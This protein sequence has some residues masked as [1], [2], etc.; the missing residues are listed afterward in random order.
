MKSFSILLFFWSIILC[1]GNYEESVGKEEIRS[2]GRNLM[3]KQRK[4]FFIENKGQWHEDVLFLCRLGGLD[5]WITKYGVNYTFYKI[6]RKQGTEGKEAHLPKG[7]FDYD[8]ESQTL[9][10]HRVLFELQGR[11]PN[12]RAEGR[13]KMEGYHNYFIGNDPTKH[14]ANVALYKEAWVKNVYDGIDMRYYFEEGYL[15]FD[16]VVQAGADASKIRFKL[17]GAEGSYLKGLGKLAFTTRFGEVV[18]ADLRTLQDKKEVYSRYE[19]EGDDWK[20]ILGKYNLSKPLIIDPLIYSTYIGGVNTYAGRAIKVDA[21]GNAY[22]CGTNI[23]GGYDVVPG[24]FDNTHNG[25]MDVFVTMVAN[26]G[27]ALNHS[28]YLG[29][30]G[31]DGVGDLFI[32]NS[33]GNIYVVGVT[34]STNFP[35]SAFPFQSSHGNNNGSNNDG[36]I[37]KFDP[38]LT[39][40]IYSSYIGGNGLD[41]VTSVYVN[42]SGEAYLAGYTSSTNFTVTNTPILQPNLAGGQDIFISKVNSSGTNILLS[43]Y[44]GGTAYDE[45]SVIKVDHSGNVYVG[46]KTQ[47]A[48]FPMVNPVQ[49][50]NNGSFDVVFC[51]INPTFSSLLISTYVGGTKE[52]VC[53]DMEVNSLNEI[54]LTGATSSTNFPT[55]NGCYD[56]SYNDVGYSDCFLTKFNS[57]GSMV[58][59]TYF[60]GLMSEE[61]LGIELDALNNIYITGL[62]SSN[63]FP[64]KYAF[65]PSKSNTFDAFILKFD[66]S[67]NT[68]LYS[69][70]LGGN[71]DEISWDIALDNMGIAYVTGQTASTDFVVTQNAYQQS[72]QGGYDV[73]VT[74]LCPEPPPMVTL[75]S[76]TTSI[77][78]TTCISVPISPVTFSSTGASTA[79][80]TGLPPGVTGFYNNG[81]FSISGTPSS[82]GIYIYTVTFSGS[83][84]SSTAITGTLNVTQ[85][86]QVGT[87]N[88]S[89]S[90]SQSVCTNHSILPITFTYS[91]HNSF[92][93]VSGLPPGVNFTNYVS[94]PQTQ[95]TGTPTQSGSYVYSITVPGSLC[96]TTLTGTISVGPPVTFTLLSPSSYTYQSPCI[97]S[98]IQPI[99]YSIN[100]VSSVVNSNIPPGVSVSQNGNTLTI[101]GTPSVSGY[102]SY[103]VFLS[104]ACGSSTVKGFLDIQPMP[105]LSVSGGSLFQNVCSGNQIQGITLNTPPLSSVNVGGLPS[106]VTFYNITNVGVISGTPTTSPGTYTYMITV[107]NTCGITS[108]TGTFVINSGNATAV[109]I[110]PPGTENQTVCVGEGITPISYSVGGVSSISVT[111]LPAGVGYTLSPG[112]CIIGG[113][114]LYPGYYPYQLTVFG[115]GSNMVVKSGTIEAL[116][117]ISM[118]VTGNSS[119]VNQTLCLGRTIE[120]IN[121]K[122][123]GSAV[124]T[125][126]VIGLPSGVEYDFDNDDQEVKIEG[127]P[128]SIGVYGYTV[129]TP[130]MCLQNSR[131]NI[132][133]MACTNLD[134]PNGVTGSGIWHI[135]NI[136]QFP[137]NEVF[138]FSR[139]GNKIAYIKGYNNKDRAWGSVQFPLNV[140]EGTYYYIIVLKD[141]KYKGYVEVLR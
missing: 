28:T 25:A 105:T 16:F 90:P 9:I 13:Q 91:G 102:Y 59:S 81:S 128:T 35:V 120:E 74:K 94:S 135:Q 85:G 118:A 133:V 60:G 61:A 21:T 62:T 132:Y 38:T 125:V 116:P 111:G 48:N 37:T 108:Q 137:D 41:G 104:G 78:Y 127:T 45:A 99:T 136:E 67:G 26:G 30:S 47:S 88:T 58:F 68:L 87:I 12:P 129:I 100:G 5:A 14:A 141:K 18:L 3:Q 97:N 115:C 66:P 140:P 27:W 65:Q 79:G 89:G 39:N 82:S 113:G 139:W 121:Y 44:L 57:N 106:G 55:T 7:K 51:K 138:I 98:S 43:T 83:V 131:G 6:E 126:Q 84:C 54:F 34:S 93:V 1:A 29:G 32:E 36:F 63:D 123:T 31:N 52:D 46:G 22:V 122:I 19:K 17:K 96:N 109:H 103:S 110:S 95:I 124:N 64:V 86:P 10:G 119:A 130:G 117:S 75:T 23:N 42:N 4:L 134:I 69:T 49:S 80:V 107:Q 24:A 20:I 92:P 71:G 33:T 53:Y 101:S 72:N 11:N 8:F 40:V 76:P 50:V 73:F 15:R 114:A 77:N 56:P 70:F 112:L 2:E